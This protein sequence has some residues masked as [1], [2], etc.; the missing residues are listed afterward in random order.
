VTGVP[1]TQQLL[2]ASTHLAAA[3]TVQSSDDS[4]H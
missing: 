4:R 2:R 3:V 1:L